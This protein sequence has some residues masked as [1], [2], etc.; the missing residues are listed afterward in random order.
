MTTTSGIDDDLPKT[1]TGADADDEAFEA[2]VRVVVPI[3]F[4]F[5]T[6]VGLVVTA[7]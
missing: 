6:V 7:S 4:G 3:V 5:V 1:T 2:T